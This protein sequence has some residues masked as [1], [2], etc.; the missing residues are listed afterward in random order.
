M[1]LN[2]YFLAGVIQKKKEELTYRAIATGL[3]SIVLSV[4]MFLSVLSINSSLNKW[5]T[6]S[7]GPGIWFLGIIGAFLVIGAC[8]GRKRKKEKLIYEWDVI[9]FDPVLPIRC[10]KL[11]ITQE[12]SLELELT[13]EE[14][15]WTDVEGIIAEKYA[16]YR[17]SCTF[18]NFF[19]I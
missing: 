19:K 2:I 10:N 17:D 18:C 3:S 7:V 12:Y 6:L 1:G 4:S 16:K 8:T 5:L 14:F 13:C 11:K 15:E 9:N